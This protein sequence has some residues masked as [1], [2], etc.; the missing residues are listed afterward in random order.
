MGTIERSKEV[1]WKILTDVHA[2]NGVSL[3][4]GGLKVVDL[5][6]DLQPADAAAESGLGVEEVLRVPE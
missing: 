4:L 2:E 6:V 3:P 1:T 5:V